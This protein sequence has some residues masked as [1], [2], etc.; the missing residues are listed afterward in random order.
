MRRPATAVYWALPSLA[1]L[2]IYWLGLNAWFSYDDFAWLSLNQRLKESG[3]LWNI[4]LAPQAQGTI[5][6]LSERAFFL[7]FHG[8]FGLDALPFHLAVFLTQFANLALLCAIARR[9]TGSRIAGLLAALLWIAN[10]TLAVVMS[11]TSAYNQ[12]LC[13][14]FILA[15]FWCLLRYVDTGKVRYWILQWAAFLAGFAALEMMAVY[16]A[17]AAG[18][19]L[20]A[21]RKHFRKTLWLL[22][23][24][25][26]YTVLHLRYAP[27]AVSGPYAMHL[28]GS[29]VRTLWTY[30]TWALCPVNLMQSILRL[31][32]WMTYAAVL[33][34]TTALLSFAAV[35]L[36][37]GNRLGVFLAFW[38]LILIGPVLP[39]RDHMSD[40]YLTMPTIGL[41]I[42]GGW[43]LADAWK[44]R[45]S[46]KAAATALAGIYLV[47]SVPYA[48]A[49]TRWQ[50][51][52]SLESRALLQGLARAAELHPGKIIILTGLRSDLF[53]SA[54]RHRAHELVGI[55]ELYIAPGAETAIERFDQLALVS[56]YVLP[57]PITARALEEG[58]AV[59]YSVDGDRPRNVTSVYAAAARARFAR[60]EQPFLVEVGSQAFV[61]QIG[62][63]W[64]QIEG[65][66]RWMPKRAT[67]SLHGPVTPDA[68]LHLSGFC[69]SQQA[70]QKPLTLTVSV[71]GVIVG[72]PQISRSNA[73]F[74]LV[75]PLSAQSLGKPKIEVAIEVDRTF[76]VP[77][78]QRE[79]GLIFGTIQVR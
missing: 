42:L 77:G 41:A 7:V 69:P 52:K 19:T 76:S 75:L 79:L 46:M 72:R 3:D 58:R 35:R 73:P 25:A 56:D 60:Q 21:A 64:Y 5:R 48:K 67:V 10:G 71:D 45:P 37:Q 33:L 6:P 62:P 29:M 78:D 20:L 34:L 9:L 15:S 66:F 61:D 44:S 47:C 24:S 49:A 65:K 2:L 4:L 39:L 74:E 54:I 68:R 26:V 53:W 36:R 57:A 38:F 12:A 63:T 13:G 28:D 55:G 32:D 51:D 11:W 22:L 30:W 17:L 16:P 1:A 40:Y 50:Y 18:Y 59:V 70:V 31:P 8:L 14:F 23:P 27:G 43:A